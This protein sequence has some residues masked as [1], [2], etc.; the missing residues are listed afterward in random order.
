[1][2]R[3]GLNPEH[4]NRYPH[5][6]SGGQRQRIGVA[7]AIALKPKLI[8]ADEPVSA[9]DVSIQAQILNLLRELQRDLGPDDH[10]HRPRPLASCATCATASRSCTSARSSSWPT[11]TSSSTT[12]AIPYTGALLSAVPVARPAAGARRSSARCS[13]ATCPSPTNPPPA[14]RF[15]T[16]CPKARDGVCDVDEPLLEAKEGGNLAACHFPLTD[17]EIASA[18]ADRRGVSASRSRRSTGGRA[19]SREGTRTAPTRRR[20][21]GCEVG[22]ICKSLVFRVGDEPLLDHRRRAPTASTRRASAPTKADAAFVREQTGFAIGGVPPFGHVRADRD[23]RRRG[24]ARATTRVG[25]GGHAAR[26]LPD[27]AG[28]LVARSG[29]RVGARRPD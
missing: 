28:E 22:A 16:R 24:P 19:S 20:A 4:Y 15:H 5:E 29:G 17:E 11:P 23:A 27:R 7:R 10:L 12:R 18:R 9:L 21:I 1:M 26:G 13:A 6:F 2:D 3:V 25:G 8:V 14:C